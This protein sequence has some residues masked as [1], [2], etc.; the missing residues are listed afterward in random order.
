MW[1]DYY[2]DESRARAVEDAMTV[3]R[4]DYDAQTERLAEA[5]IANRVLD[6]ESA[7]WRHTTA[8]SLKALGELVYSLQNGGVDAAKNLARAE[9]LLRELRVYWNTPSGDRDHD[10]DA[11]LNTISLG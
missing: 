3:R 5:L 8:R 6:A 10:L 11:L 7:G 1:G 4:E 9:A 2:E